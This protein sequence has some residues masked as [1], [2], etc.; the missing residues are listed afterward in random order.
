[1][2]GSGQN[3]VQSV[4]NADNSDQRGVE[5]AWKVHGAISD[6]TAKV[7]AKAAIVLSL[8]GVVLGFF[9]TLSV[10]GRI[11]AHLQG[12]HLTLE[13]LGIASTAVGVLLATLV[14]IPRL[15][16]RVTSAN[17]RENF[18]YFGHLRRWDPADLKAKLQSLSADQELDV[19]ATQLVKTSKIAWYKHSLLQF[20]VVSL[21][22]GVALISFSV[23]L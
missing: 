11:L 12:W 4:P 23:V 19:L 5:F 18:V 14:V 16:R 22:L 21:V 17:W 7:D 15:N 8:G 13:R 20:G 2:F 9:V 3:P 6:W 1:M 10:D